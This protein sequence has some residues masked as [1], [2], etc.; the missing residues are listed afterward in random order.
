MKRTENKKQ[1][2]RKKRSGQESGDRYQN[3]HCRN[4][5][6]G[7]PVGRFRGSLGT[8]FLA[9]PSAEATEWQLIVV[10]TE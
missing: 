5:V 9:F 2:A 10:E 7:C 3:V 8:A 1:V 6:D 4:F